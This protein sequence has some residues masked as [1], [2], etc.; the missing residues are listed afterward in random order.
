MSETNINPIQP[1]IV[2]PVQQVVPMQNASTPMSASPEYYAVPM[3]VG[4]TSMGSNASL[5]SQLVP[6]VAGSVLSTI[7]VRFIDYLTESEADESKLYEDTINKIKSSGKFKTLKEIEEDEERNRRQAELERYKASREIETSDIFGNRHVLKLTQKNRV[8]EAIDE[9]EQVKQKIVE[10]LEGLRDAVSITRC[11]TCKGKIETAYNF[12]ASETHDIIDITDKVVAIQYL[13]DM[14]KLP[15]D[16]RWETLDD[17]QKQIVRD[18]VL[19]LH[20]D[21]YYNTIYGSRRE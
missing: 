12:V 9:A 19:D 10:S 3:A 5:M 17:D 7:A 16:A 6:R 2:Y 11:K 8:E 13:K 1:L 4:A 20:G 18:T 14:G 21:D 15:G